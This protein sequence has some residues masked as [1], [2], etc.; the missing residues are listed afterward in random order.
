MNVASQSNDT[1]RAEFSIIKAEKYSTIVASVKG[2]TPE[3]K[4]ILQLIDATNNKILKTQKDIVTGRYEF[5]YMPEG[6]VR[7][8]ITEDLNGNGEWDS[9]DLIAR[10]SA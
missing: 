7:V 3:S 5:R 9:G 4:Y 8:R 2:K 10:R 1:L 6:A